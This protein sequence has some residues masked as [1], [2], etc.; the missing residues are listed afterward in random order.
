M[1]CHKVIVPD[2]KRGPTA[3]FV[4]PEPVLV[5]RANGTVVVPKA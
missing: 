4:L 5:A 1:E 2:P 3:A